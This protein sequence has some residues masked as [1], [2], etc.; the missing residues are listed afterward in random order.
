MYSKSRTETF[1]FILLT[2]FIFF[3]LNSCI[4]K[5][6][7]NGTNLKNT[8]Y[9]VIDSLVC[10]KLS[11]DIRGL[12][13]G[14]DETLTLFYLT[15]G[16]DIIMTGHKGYVVFSKTK[17]LDEIGKRISIEKLGTDVHFV[18]VLLEQ[19]TN[20]S[21]HDLSTCVDNNIA[22]TNLTKIDKPKLQAIL[23]DDDLL[24]AKV[25]SLKKVPQYKKS[26]TKLSGIHLF[27]E[28]EYWLHWHLE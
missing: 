17:K 25:I 19:D 13:S 6:E 2:W 24:D 26:K 22:I 4:P 20:L 7:L 1:R 11:E 14:D 21:A 27:D 23:G 5:K 12:A 3:S 16:E 8:T 18:I 15:N 9:L 28:Y 10:K